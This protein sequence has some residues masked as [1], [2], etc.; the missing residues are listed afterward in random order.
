MHC[1]ERLLVFNRLSHAATVCA[2]RCGL[3]VHDVCTMQA[4]L[5]LTRR[6]SVI[7]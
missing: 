1:H 7:L 2:W 5:Q 6:Q 3:I 4:H